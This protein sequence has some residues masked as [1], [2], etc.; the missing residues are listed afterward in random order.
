MWRIPTDTP[1]IAV[2]NGLKLAEV[3][4]ETPLDEVFRHWKE[5]G[6]IILKNILTTS[7]A[8]Q[9]T[10]E[11]ES[12]LDSVQ[13]GS[14]IPH[15]DLAAFHGT[16]TKR[17]G[18]IINHSATFRQRI[19][20]NDFI[21]SI[22]KRCYSEGGH[23]G[24]YWLSAATTLNASGPQPAQVL[25]RDLTSYPPYAQLGPEGTEPQINFLFAFSDFTA[26]NGA[27]RV[28]SGSNK[29][30]FDQRG[31]ME[32][33]IPAEMTTG[34][35][36]LIG[37][38]VIHAM[39]ENKTEME[40]KCIQLTVIPSFLTPAEAHPFII[41]LETAK[42]L[43]KRAQ[44]FVGFRS[45]YPRGSPG[46]WTKDYIELALH[47]GLDDLRGAMEALQ[48]VIEQPKQWD[49]VDYDQTREL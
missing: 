4:A 34:D 12:R 6:G 11:L 39:G 24:D 13:R 7:E 46:L 22:C 29:W 9:I 10:K 3:T 32:Q 19:L 44:R 21:H 35:C 36:L 47:L 5:S 25:H 49:T 14:L 16:K 37:G 31:N 2:S 45:Q 43:S 48:E 28:I 17:A 30:A 15:P 38:K 41:K 26:D 18:D 20:E 1:Q 40:R 33:T 27:T 42:K 23:N 8:N